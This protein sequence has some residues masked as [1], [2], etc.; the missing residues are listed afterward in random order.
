MAD[1]RLM[2]N[3]AVSAYKAGKLVEAE[4]LCQQIIT[5]ESDCFFAFHILA[6]VQSSLGKKG[7]A[8]AN[9]DRALAVQPDFAETLNNRG[10]IL[11]GL[12]RFDEALASFDRALAVQ[13]DYAE[14]SYNRGN[15]LRDL[16]RFDEALASYDHVLAVRPNH[17]EA[18][19]NRGAILQELKRLEEALA[20]YDRALAVRPDFVEALTHCGLVLHGL[21]RFDEALASFDHALAVRPNYAEAL[22]NRSNLLRDLKRFDEALASCDRALAVRPDFAEA[23]NNR[24]SI[25]QELRRFDE[26]LVSYDRALAVSPNYPEALYNR[27]ATLHELKRF[28]EA[29]ASYGR[30]IAVSPNYAEAQFND[31]LCRL[32]IG[33]FERGWDKYEWR[34]RT[35][36][37]RDTK[38]SFAQPLWLGHES[39]E[40]KTIL[41]HAEQGFGDTIQFCRYVP[42]VAARG[43]YVILQVQKPLQE[44]MRDLAGVTHV[45]A[46]GDLLPDFDTHCPLG[47]LPRAFGT[48]RETIPA[49]VPYL[50]V[51]KI[52]SEKWEQRLPEP[53]AVRVGICW[54][55]NPHFKGDLARS[56]GLLPMLPLLSA[57]GVEF[58]SIQKDLRPGDAE[59]LKNHSQIKHLGGEIETFGDTAAVISSMDLVISSDTSVVH[60]AGAL[61]KSVWILLQ[62]V[63]DWRWLVDRDDNP[64]YPTARLFRQDATRAWDNVITQVHA[65]LQAFARSRA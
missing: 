1:L 16:K 56:I 64:W 52:Y 45:I 51:P 54:A 26:A 59:V 35:E 46:N 28:D 18:L 61:G 37:A 5:T 21:K 9:Y 58:F 2:L 4:Q 62:F 36:Q 13:P 31:A 14:A 22:H 30:A 17:A 3:D 33:D 39:I 10:A 55:G 32:L 24:G 53:A 63:P 20:S 34:R 25:L 60:L 38:R 44:L 12:K 11:H 49:D 43:A 40:G 8:L 29:L 23:L 57:A 47:S 15:S 48:Q 42:L 6:A 19:F 65:A 41:L 7:E 50:V 27:G